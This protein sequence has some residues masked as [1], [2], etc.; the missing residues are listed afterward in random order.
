VIV[1]KENGILGGNACNESACYRLGAFVQT[2]TYACVKG[3]EWVFI[4]QLGWKH[5]NFVL[6]PYGTGIFYLEGGFY[7]DSNYIT[8][9]FD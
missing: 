2:Q 4:D 5:G 9:W 6:V 1:T 7:Y 3:F 8:G